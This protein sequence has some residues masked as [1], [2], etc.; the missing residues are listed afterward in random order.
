[1][2]LFSFNIIFRIQLLSLLLLSIWV[3][4]TRMTQCYKPQW[5][6]AD[7]GD[8]ADGP[9]TSSSGSAANGSKVRNTKYT[10]YNNLP[11]ESHDNDDHLPGGHKAGHH[12][13]HS[14]DGYKF[15]PLGGGGGGSHHHGF[16]SDDGY[17]FDPFLPPLGGGH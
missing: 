5:T 7:K 1:M 9:D 2:N 6:F 4:S 3:K 8:D 15:D 10:F 12:A 14:D 13:W 17:R 16:Q 11:R